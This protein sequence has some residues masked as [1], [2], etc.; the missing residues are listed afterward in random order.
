MSLALTLSSASHIQ[1]RYE[2]LS[3]YLWSTNLNLHYHQDLILSDITPKD[4]NFSS[5]FTLVSTAKRR[6]KINA[7]VLY[8]DTFFTSR[9]LPIPPNTKV[10]LIKE[11]E[12][13]L[14]ELWPV[15]G[16][17]APQRRQSMGGKN[18]KIT[19]FSTGPL[20]TPTHWK[21]TIFMLRDPITV[22]EGLWACFISNVNEV[23]LI[24]HSILGSVV[25]GTF[26]CRKSERNSRELEAE[27]HYSVKLDEQAS[28][29][30]TIV[31]MYKVR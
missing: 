15:G 8:F 23:V 17:S 10:K 29:S 28:P 21:Q 18:E 27:I 30:E 12:A 19:S 4:L 13:V 31:Q 2:F 20:S 16:K 3:I 1:S 7:F 6:T 9:G 5:S 26:K 24:N 14:A 25:V 22:S 11:G